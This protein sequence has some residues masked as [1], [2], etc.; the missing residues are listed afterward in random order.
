M[1]PVIIFMVVDLPEPLG[2][3]DDFAGAR[4]S[5]RRPGVPGAF[6][7]ATG[8]VHLVRIKRRAG[9]RLPTRTATNAMKSWGTGPHH[10]LDDPDHW[11]W[12][13]RFPCP[14][15]LIF[16]RNGLLQD[17]PDEGDEISRSAR[18][19]GYAE[20]FFRDRRTDAP[21]PESRE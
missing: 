12:R 8:S 20:Q 16:R 21:R 14:P 17:V 15:A 5:R 7:N 9:A 10:Y 6:G 13:R 19:G 18:A 2:R 11:L 1:S 4:Q 3:V